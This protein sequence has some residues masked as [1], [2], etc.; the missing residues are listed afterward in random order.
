[1]YPKDCCKI[2]PPYVIDIPTYCNHIMQSYHHIMT[3]RFARGIIYKKI[4]IYFE[5]DMELYENDMK[6]YEII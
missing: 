3:S 6:L 5:N 2:Q 4:L 1:M